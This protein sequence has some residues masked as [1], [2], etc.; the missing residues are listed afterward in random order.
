MTH[1]SSGLSGFQRNGVTAQSV[2][3]LDLVELVEGQGKL[4]GMLVLS[5]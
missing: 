5:V 1:C 4:A 2:L 3:Q